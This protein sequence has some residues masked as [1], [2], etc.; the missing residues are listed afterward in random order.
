MN[1]NLFNSSSFPAAAMVSFIQ[2]VYIVDEGEKRA[3]VCARVTPKVDF[4]F[5][6]N[7]TTEQDDDAG[8]NS[9][10]IFQ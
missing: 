1:D 6:V 9:S 7:F 8:I 3:L 5:H 4:P 2:T 10:S